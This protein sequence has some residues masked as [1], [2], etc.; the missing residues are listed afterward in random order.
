[1]LYDVSDHPRIKQGALYV[2]HFRNVQFE[3]K[4]AEAIGFFKTDHSDQFL[5][6]EFSTRQSSVS[7]KEGM[8]VKAFDKG[9]LVIGLSSSDGL[10]VV[11]AV[12]QADEAA[13][14]RD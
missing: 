11:Q 14:W 13:Y 5:T 2:A 1:H 9:A 3:G 8:R 4:S 12:S 7:V 10:R 6:A